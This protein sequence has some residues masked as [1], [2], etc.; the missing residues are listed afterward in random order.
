MTA[1][2][3]VRQHVRLDLIDA[4]LPRDGFGRGFIV[5]GQHDDADALAM[6]RVQRL[7]RRRLDRIGDGED[8]AGPAIDPDI[9]R[10]GA[11][12]TQR[13]CL[14]GQLRATSTPCSVRN[15][16]LPSTIALPSTLPSA[17]LPSGESKSTTGGMAMP[18]FSAASTIASASGCSDA[19][20]TP[21]A[22][23]RISVLVEA[24]RRND[25]RHRRLALGERAG[26]VDHQ[27]VD[28]LHMLERLGVLDQDAG[29][30]R[31]CR[32]RP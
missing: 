17:P 6:Q 16:A 22:S 32:R 30:P 3:C 26:L 24:G 28:L 5:A 25:R 12:M 1:L 13:I 9:D 18:F 23:R 14:A 7:R 31:P 15:T 11:I 19:F 20:S 21:A 27:R 4:E 10:G 2:F 8:A 29:T